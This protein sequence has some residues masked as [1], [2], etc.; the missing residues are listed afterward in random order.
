MSERDKYLTEAMGECWHV[1]VKK[2]ALRF[3]H[4]AFYANG[5]VSWLEEITVRAD[6]RRQGLGLGLM[7]AFEAWGLTRI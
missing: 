3:D 6:L 2:W 7:R 4:Y 1:D 5:R